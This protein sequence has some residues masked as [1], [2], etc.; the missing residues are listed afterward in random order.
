MK[1]HPFSRYLFDIYYDLNNHNDQILSLITSRYI[2]LITPEYKTLS[3]EIYF[4]SNELSLLIETEW[5]NN[6]I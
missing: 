1:L 3:E 4:L 5:P 6:A 2:F